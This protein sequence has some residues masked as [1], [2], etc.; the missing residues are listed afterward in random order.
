MKGL[1]LLLSLFYSLIL[2]AQTFFDSFGDGEFTSNPAWGG[3]AQRWIVTD[4]TAGPDVPGSNTLRLNTNN[5]GSDFLRTPN[6]IWAGASESQAWAFWMGRTASA[7]GSNQSIVWLFADDQNLDNNHINGYRIVFGEAGDDALILQRVVDGSPS[8][9]LVST[10]ETANAVS[11]FG[12]RVRVTRSATGVWEIF[13]GIS[14][15]AITNN[16]GD[17]ASSDPIG[18]NFSQGS[19]QEIGTPVPITGT[20]YFGF[21]AI[22]N[23]NPGQLTGAQ[24]DQ[25]FYQAAGLLPVRFTSFDV[26]K[27]DARARL[28]WKVADEKNVDGYQVERSANGVQF[29]NLGYVKANGGPN[30]NFTDEKIL[31]GA[32]FYRVKNVDIDGKFAYTHIVSINGKKGQFIR[33]FPVPART[34]LYIQHHETVS[35]AELNITSM[36]GRIV[37]VIKVPPNATQT[38]I[39]LSTMNSGVYF[40]TYDAGDGN[41]FV[42]K[43]IKQ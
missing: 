31:P 19:A 25:F 20:G 27:D 12:F 38:I 1:L 43:F 23:A 17:P 22:N 35:G 15:S 7:E 39:D 6:L 37:R 13:T 11:D 30:Y 40:A 5:A 21:Y 4:G 16:G 26:I 10:E 9:I 24:F 41:K 34:D 32:N 33:I 28:N 8:A 18:I 42:S 14:M 29:S 36:E 3:D 2:P